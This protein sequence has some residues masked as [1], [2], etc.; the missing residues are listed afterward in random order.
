M[1]FSH[2]GMRNPNPTKNRT[3]RA[4]RMQTL[5]FLTLA[6]EGI[7]CWI[8]IEAV[9]KPHLMSDSCVADLFKI[10]AH[11]AYGGTVLFHQPALVE[12]IK[13]LEQEAK[14]RYLAGLSN[15]I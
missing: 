6:F 15:M 10:D 5:I 2:N 11:P 12:H 3:I 14:S 8:W 13:F 9:S 4:H 1:I 7:I